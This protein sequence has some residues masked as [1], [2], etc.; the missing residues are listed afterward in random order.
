MRIA[1]IRVAASFVCAALFFE[2]QAFT[3][4]LVGLNPSVSQILYLPLHPDT[5]AMS[6]AR[7]LKAPTLLAIG[8][9]RIVSHF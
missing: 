3:S 8:L 9:K 7:F 6:P 1:L 2:A 4:N 5:F